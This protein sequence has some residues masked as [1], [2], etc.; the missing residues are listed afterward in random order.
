MKRNIVPLLGIAFVVAIV[1]TGVFYGLFAGRMRS[2]SNELPGQT[3]VVAARDLDRGTVVKS[4]DLAVSQLKGRLKG[5]FSKP[6]DAVGATLLERVQQ[7]EPLLEDRVAS[8]DP[9]VGGA[10][11][12]TVPAG[13]RVVSIRVSESTGVVNLLHAGNKVDIQAV[14]EHNGTSELRTIVQNVEVLAVSPQ[15]EPVPGRQPAPVLTLL[16]RA[17]DAD[18]IALADSGAR[19]RVALRNPLDDSAPPRHALELASVFSGAG[20]I[21]SVPNV[22]KIAAE[23]HPGKPADPSSLPFDHPIQLEVRVLGASPAALDELDSKLNGPGADASMRVATF[24]PGADIDELV[25]E[26]EQK[27]ELEIVSASKLTAGV[28]RPISFHAGSSPNQFRVQFSPEADSGGKVSLR[29]KPEIT[30]QRGEGVETRKYDVDL[31]DGGS[32]LVTGLLRSQRDR[33]VLDRLFPGHSW[34]SRE[35]VIFVTAKARKQLP[36]SAFAQTNRGQ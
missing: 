11:K 16:V 15:T 30:L 29:V 22:Q 20:S 17:G 34:G 36:A 6:E 26:L 33:G 12:G 27:Q 24:R 19:I 5:S 14:L 32:F 1:S 4:S 9:A 28:G 35:L 3:I 31:P 21:P 7:N 23:T 13:M 2:A 25:K 18:A 10:A 8:R